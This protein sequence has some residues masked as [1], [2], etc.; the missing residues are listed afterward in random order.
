[1]LVRTNLFQAEAL[2]FYNLRK[3]AAL[4]FVIFFIVLAVRERR[5]QLID[6]QVPVEFLDGAGSPERVITGGNV[7]GRLI[8][9]CRKH[10]RRNKAL[11]DQ[12]VKF[13]EILIEI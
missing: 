5:G 2:P 12:L 13:E 11:P 10:L 7:D 9:D 8:E 1:M 3:R 6:A 4:A